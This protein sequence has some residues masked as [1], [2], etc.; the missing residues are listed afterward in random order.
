MSIL[1]LV[2]AALIIG[3]A[4]VW[5]LL[6]RLWRAS[7]GLPHGRSL[8]DEQVQFTV[9]RPTAVAPNRW[10][11]ML[12]FGHLSERRPDEPGEPDPIEEM[13]RQARASLGSE[14]GR[15]ASRNQDSRSAVPRGGLV[16]FLPEIPG[17][18]FNPPRYTFKW[19][20]AVHREEF[21]FRAGTAALGTTLRGSVRIYL[22]ALLLAEVNLAIAVEADAVTAQPTQPHRAAAFRRVFAS[23]SHKDL[24]IV[25]QYENYLALLGDEVL[26]DWKHLKPGEV[27]NDRLME[28]IRDADVFQ[29]FWSKNSMQSEVVRRE[30]EYAMSLN[31]DRFV[32]PTYWETPMPMA[33][34][35]PPEQLK[36]LHFQKLDF[37]RAGRRAPPR[38]KWIAGAGTVAAI[39][40]VGVSVLWT[41][42][43]HD[44]RGQSP[45][46]D[47]RSTM[48]PHDAGDTN[49]GPPTE[50]VTIARYESDLARINKES[51]PSDWAA[52]QV[53]LGKALVA[54]TAGDKSTNLKRA[55]AAF[56]AA[57]TVY[58]KQHDPWAWAAT[59][60]ELALAW[61]DLPA[62]NDAE[63]AENLQ[64][65]IAAYQSAHSGGTD[66][67]DSDAAEEL[68]DLAY[69]YRKAVPKPTSRDG[70]PLPDSNR[71]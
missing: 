45:S 36:S 70:S 10:H 9:Y 56:D 26:R 23:Y 3:A 44:R 65:A 51:D 69:K 16:T 58:T 71:Q 20:E 49:A 68:S 59:Q 25:E 67:L 12:V 52:T 34:G 39:A 1:G 40:L 27:W 30:W 62:T 6:P 66:E 61:F 57:L 4:V 47:T 60:A 24:A 22:G 33:A 11:T 8:V 32:C 42:N 5:R 43:A 29:L 63:R 14:F 35:L 46:T 18:E 37:G 54:R 48:P 38:T 21:R 31:R 28:L 64:H 17:V 53:V 2:L 50:Q 15:Y 19:V 55:I 41:V 7:T 13:E